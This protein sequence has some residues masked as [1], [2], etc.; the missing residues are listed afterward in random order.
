MSD[1]APARGAWHPEQVATYLA[2]LR[3][4]NLGGRRMFPKDAIRAAV[5]STG[6]TDVETYISTGNVRLDSSLGSADEVAEVLERAFAADRGFEV[7]TIV[8]EP[9][10]LVRI[11]ADADELWRTEGEPSS[12]Y[13]TLL[14]AVPDPDAVE[15][16]H[17]VEVEG[18]R[19]HVRGRAAHLLLHKDFH[20]SRLTGS[21]ALEGLGVGTARNV[22]VVR[23]LVQRWCG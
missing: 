22:T 15:R 10:E 19:L 7:P 16:A 11:A 9:P 21:K 18:E 20:R 3:A 6:A 1:V 13:V 17:A 2:F 14:K 5:A 12:H 8:L 23:T 4:I